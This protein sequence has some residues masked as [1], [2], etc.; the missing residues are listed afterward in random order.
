MQP[1]E[2]MICIN[3]FFQCLVVLVLPPQGLTAL[4][5]HESRVLYFSLFYMCKNSETELGKNKKYLTSRS[6]ACQMKK[7]LWWARGQYFFLPSF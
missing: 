2:E 7:Y 1:Q 3:L 4:H 6:S 5:L